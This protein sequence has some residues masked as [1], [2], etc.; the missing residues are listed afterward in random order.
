MERIEVRSRRFHL[1]H[2]F[3]QMVQD[4]GKHAIVPMA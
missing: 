2:V 1:G 4:K 3:F